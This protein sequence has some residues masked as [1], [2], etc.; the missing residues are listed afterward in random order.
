[1]S[2]RR[3]HTRVTFVNASGVL[4]VS[5]DVVVEKVADDEFVAVSNEPGIAGD[6]LTIAFSVKQAREMVT[7]R[8][9]ASRPRLVNGA[10]KH[11]LKL[12]RVNSHA[13]Y[14]AIDRGAAE[15][16]SE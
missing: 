16:G 10:V 9:M 1:M 15:S 6:V 11:E 14:G 3:N 13:A 7:V 8:V 5:R 2:G 4:R 12:K